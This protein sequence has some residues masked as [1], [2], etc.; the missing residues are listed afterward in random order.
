M[1]W[2]PR[3]FA[4]FVIAVFA[5]ITTVAASFVAFVD[6]YWLWR[7]RVAWSFNPAL[8]NRMRFAKSL[9]VLLRR[10]DVVLL[11]SSVVYRGIDPDDIENAS[12]YNLGIASLRIREAE[13]YVRYLLRWTRPKRIII[14]IDYFAFDRA[15]PFESGFDP[16]LTETAYLA[17]AGI[18]AFVSATAM[19]DAWRLAR[20]HAIDRDGTWDRNGFKR[21]RARTPEEISAILQMTRKLIGRTDV[22]GSELSAL[23]NIIALARRENVQ[24]LLFVPPYHRSWIDTALEARRTGLSFGEWIDEVASLAARHGV[25][26]WDFASANPT[27]DGPVGAGS[28]HYL[29][30]SHFSPLLGRWILQRLGVGVRIDHPPP[31]DFGR[32]LPVM[33]GSPQS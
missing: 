2:P 15:Q 10:P 9:Q 20:R 6:P 12:A 24:L 21:T 17:K 8:E 28:D 5:A 27:S 1:A 16:T 14:G 3:R 26:I 7:E 18:G 11:G 31:A 22:S 29:D 33:V 30:P 4:L 13:A 23:A 25:E 19:A 32:R